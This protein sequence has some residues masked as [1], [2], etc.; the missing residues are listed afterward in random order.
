MKAISYSLFGYEVG[1]YKNC[2]EFNSYLVGL[3]LSIRMN[4]LVFPGWDTVVHIDIKTYQA[5]EQFFA[6]LGRII[7]IK[8]ISK[9]PELCEA[10]LWRLKPIF[11]RDSTGKYKY[12]HIL[13]RDLDSLHTYREAQAV[14]VWLDGG[15]AAHAITDSISHTIPMMGGM[16]G[17][18]TGSFQEITG[19]PTYDE[20]LRHNTYDLSVKGADQS[21]I[22]KVIY[23]KFSQMGNDSITQHYFKGHANTW[24]S[25]F[26]KCECWLY[27][28]ALGHKDDC[29]EN[30]DIDLLD[31]LKATNEISEHM[32]AAGFNQFQTMSFVEKYDFMFEDLVDLERGYPN[33]FYWIKT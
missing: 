9:N 16:I 33:I 28:S 1:K 27:K 14:K 20:L 32:G 7:K 19:Y 23:P 26:H 18:K 24:L 10:M 21:F 13:C 4:R 8:V 15:K 6:D 3:M 17:F 29:P 5:F 22:N 30:V 2:F 25:D 31:E 12:S 11:S